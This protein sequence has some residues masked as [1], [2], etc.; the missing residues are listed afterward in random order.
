MQLI[1]R[2]EINYLRSLYAANLNQIGN[3][4]IMFGRNDSGKSNLLRALNLFFNDE[5]DPGRAFDFDLDMSDA[6]KKEAQDA[7]GRQSIWI[8][9]TF[10]TPKNF[11]KSLG[12]KFFIKRQWNRDGQ[13]TESNSFKAMS[14]GQQIQLTKLR[15]QIDFTYIPAIKDLGVYADLIERMYSAAAETPELERATRNFVDTIQGQ[16]TALSDE[17]SALFG[18]LARLAPPTE[19]SRLF[20]NLD[21]AHGE[22]GHSLLRQKGDGVKA[23][24]LPELLRF[25]NESEARKRFF[26]WGFEEPENSLDLGAAEKEADRFASFARRGDTQIFITSHSPAFYLAGVAEGQTGTRRFF[27]S[28]QKLNATSNK[29]TPP[30][31]A[32][33]IDTLKEADQQMKGGGLMQLPYVIARLEDQQKEAAELRRESD[34]LSGQ[35]DSMRRPTLFVEGRHD[36][37]LFRRALRRVGAHKQE[38][39]V[40][41]LGGTPSTTASLLKGVKNG[42]G[43]IGRAP[44]FFLFD[45]DRAGRKAFR[46]ISESQP[47]NTPFNLLEGVAAWVLPPT[48]EFQEFMQEYGVRANLASFTAEFLFPAQ[49]AAQLCLDLVRPLRSVESRT[50]RKEIRNS[51]WTG[52][53][54]RNSIRLIDAECGTVPWLYA[55][56][57]LDSLKK[58]FTQQAVV[59][60]LATDGVDAIAHAVLE[61]LRS[62]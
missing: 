4:N 44:T 56:G 1:R 40:C 60:N 38:I 18:S 39:S 37:S 30:N 50:W 46:N 61:H 24:H 35:L 19:M 21:F 51:Y 25:I 54:Q 8:K 16:T 28:K 31:A 11:R 58:E 42:G 34:A 43:Q 48:A 13:V 3:L 26:L 12:E 20:R 33:P 36:V 57:V 17:L 10:S 7:K 41:A 14:M 23:R 5:T 22:E 49:S 52:L 45:N 2:I 59:R 15:N 47:D 29:M 55:R 27:I 62:V 6:R 9:V 53:K 32:C